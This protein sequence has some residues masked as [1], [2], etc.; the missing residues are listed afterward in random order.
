MGRSRDASSVVVLEPALARVQGGPRLGTHLSKIVGFD[1]G[2][3]PTV[4]VDGATVVAR[5]TI[6]VAREDVGREATITFLEGDPGRPVITGLFVD[7][8][9]PARRRRVKLKAEEIDLEGAAQLTLTC[10]KA[11]IT[12]RRDGKIVI[13]GVE[14]V[15]RASGTNRIRGGTIELN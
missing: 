12:L 4:D 5:A 14:V 7:P 10:G 1:A 6:A 8:S 15:S 9:A 13:R 3:L 2:G 11:S